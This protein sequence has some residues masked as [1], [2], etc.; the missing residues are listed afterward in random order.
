HVP[1]LARECA[2]LACIGL[3][4]LQQKIRALPR[5]L[6]RGQPLTLGYFHDARLANWVARKLA[7]HRFDAIYVYCS[8]MAQYA[9]AAEAPRR[10]LDMVDVD[11]EKWAAYAAGSRWSGRVLWA[12]E[13]RA[14]LEF[15]RYAAQR[16]DHTLFVSEEESRRFRDLAPESAARIDWFA[17]GVD[18]SHFDPEQQF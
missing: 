4:P 9:M 14:L 13:A 10:I 1:R 8:A 11:S 5:L 17:N 12:R 16:F 6:R 3:N 18:A 2:D 7:R 15:E